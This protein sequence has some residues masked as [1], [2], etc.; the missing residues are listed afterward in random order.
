MAAR[1]AEVF[2][3]EVYPVHSFRH[4]LPLLALGLL[5]IACTRGPGEETTIGDSGDVETERDVRIPL[6]ETLS[7]TGDDYLAFWG[8]READGV[9]LVGR[10]EGAA[11]ELIDGRLT[12]DIAGDWIIQSEDSAIRVIVDADYLNEDTF[13]NFN[14]TPVRPLL[15]A[16]ASTLWVASPPSN[17]IQEITV[18][19]DG[20]LTAGRLVPTG[21]WPVA[22]AQW[23][24]RILVAQAGRDNLGIVDPAA[25]V[26]VDAIP[27]GD[28]PATIIVD[29]DY[30]YVALGGANQ[31]VKVDLLAAAVVGRVDVGRKTR[32]MAFDASRGKLY[33]ASLVS[34]NGHPRGL[35]QDAPIPESEQPDIA[36]ID[37]ASFQ[38][39]GWVNAVGTIIRGLYVDGDRLLAAV[40]DSRN[41]IAGV[42][43]DS[44][45]HAYALAVIDIAAGSA[46]VN[47]VTQRI[48]LD[49]QD[50]SSGPAPS[51][52]T[53][54]RTSARDGSDELIV[55]LSAGN[56]LLVLDAVTLAEKTRLVTGNDPRGITFVGDQ[57]ITYAWLDNAVQRFA[58][59][60][61]VQSLEVGRDPTPT[62]IKEGQRIFNDATF[63]K[64][65]DFS[66]NNCHIDGLT[67]GLVWNI[68]LDGDVN[69]LSF[70]NV[71]GTGPFLWG[72]F[73]PTLFDF[74]REVLRLVGASATGEEM[75]KLTEYMQSV[76]APPN[77][78]TLPGGRLDESQQRGR[79]LFF[80][81]GGCGAC[82]S[83]PLF[84]TAEVVSPGK[85]DK[86]T[87]I[88]SLVATYD[89]GPWGREAQWTSLGAMVDF[90]VDYVGS[91]LDAGEREDLLGYV[92]ALPADVL[93][94][95]SSAPQGQS[96]NVFSGV[97]PEMVFSSILAEGQEGAFTFE[98]EAEGAWGPV[99][100][101][102]TVAGRRAR[103]QASEPL[104]ADTP[105]R[106]RASAGLEGVYGR[107]S[108]EV[109]EVPF[110][111]GQEALTDMSGAWRLSFSGQVSGEIDIA[112]LQATGGKV[113]GALIEANGDIEFDNV[114]GYVAGTRLYIDDFL[115]DT[116]YG[117]VLVDRI[118]L[119]LS[120]DNGDGYAESGV[121]QLYSIVTLNASATRLSLPG[122]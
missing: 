36:V 112:F 63:S 81:D 33:A 77:P 13:L 51:P 76:T 80:G 38:V 119:D 117:E 35:L 69:T 39:E 26:V 46:S 87:D 1:L 47:T 101:A 12:P 65:G 42:E 99:D 85:T 104:K 57:L 68:L 10:P 54:E 25:G 18:G 78:F 103:F 41:E 115:A 34:S 2:I 66:C 7:L 96:T 28:E 84:T 59:T 79:E 44:R 50:S 108:P 27:V 64:N 83:G 32:A 91:E 102:W 105:Y 109:I 11:A 67:D 60:T 21:S 37:A 53:I 6:G 97:A 31:V 19:E 17:A 73:L 61:Q 106:M 29:G 62:R 100:G 49:L 88:P 30:A 5:G 4:R 116:P 113:T 110:A 89:S 75:E 58:S 22:L 15:Q 118:E 40:S 82:H 45:P 121:G 86:P 74:S 92:R 120:D 24:D 23:N 16:D 90:A 52:F 93:Y 14:Y 107:T 43:A 95:N 48:D 20:T 55:S 71:S 56:A 72:G 8:L 114:Q 3:D 94:L 9:E 122:E 111:T 70:R 98:V